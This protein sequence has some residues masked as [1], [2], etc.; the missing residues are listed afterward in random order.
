MIL[1]IFLTSN[2]V[3]FLFQICKNCRL[4]SSKTL[5]MNLLLF[6]HLR[7]HLFHYFLPVYWVIYTFNWILY[8][9]FL[10][11]TFL[12]YYF[13]IYTI[14]YIYTFL[15]MYLCTYIIANSSKSQECCLQT[16][17]IFVK[18]TDYT[19]TYFRT[20]TNSSRSTCRKSSAL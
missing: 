16:Q 1:C 14:F 18:Y 12:Y 2:Y 10:Y 5:K 4:S 8:T 7:K 11:F 17:T 13:Y 3:V 15:W 6:S 19:L 9:L 20:M